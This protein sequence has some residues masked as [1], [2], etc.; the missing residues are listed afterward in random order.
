MRVTTMTVEHR[1][2]LELLPWYINGTLA[3]SERDRIERHVSECLP[4]NAAL[5]EERRLHSLVQD[6]ASIPVGPEHGIKDLWLRVDRGNQRREFSL[7]LPTVGYGLAAA[8]GGAVVWAYFALNNSPTGSTAEYATL[9]SVSESEPARVDIVFFEEPSSDE[10]NA[11][12]D[13]FGGVLIGGPSELGRYTIAL[14][15]GTESTLSEILT[16]LQANPKIR[17]AGR[18]YAD[19]ASETGET[20]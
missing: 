10:L 18:S 20:R 7:S 15:T 2:V 3:G 6:Q 11:L 19:N 12:I 9:S 17:F 8:L 16:T 14:K 13:E 1:E 4:C 5:K